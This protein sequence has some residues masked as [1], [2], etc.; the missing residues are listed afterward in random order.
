MKFDAN[1]FYFMKITR[2]EFFLS[3]LVTRYNNSKIVKN[4]WIVKNFAS[5]S[6]IYFFNEI[7]RETNRRNSLRDEINAEK[8]SYQL[9]VHYSFLMKN[10]RNVSIRREFRKSMSEW[11]NII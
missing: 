4:G 9:T 11:L 1:F 8:E 3:Y 7:K 2:R 10:Y 5:F 6:C